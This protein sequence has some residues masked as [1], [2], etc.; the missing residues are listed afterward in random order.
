MIVT[1][2]AGFIGSHLVDFLLK[3]DYEV[4]GVDNLSTGKIENLRFALR[5]RNFR[6]FKDES[7]NQM[8]LQ[9]F[10]P[11]C[12]GLFHLAGSVGVI[13]V[14]KNPL[15]TF[16][17]NTESTTRILEAAARC[18]IRTVF[19]S[20]SEVY[21]KNLKNE[22]SETDDCIIG[23]LSELRWHYML[24][25]L[26]GEAMALS[27]F[28]EAGL[29]V[30]ICRLFNT[31]GPR[32][33]SEFGMV[34]PSFIKA[35][36]SGQTLKVY[37]DGGQSRVFCHVN[38]VVSAL[39]RVWAEKKCAGEIINVGGNTE[40]TILALAN[41]ILEHTNSNS[42]IEF[43]DERRINEVHYTDVQRRVPDIRKILR[44][45]GWKPELTLKSIIVES[46]LHHLK[47]SHV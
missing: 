8:L 28:Q 24:S 16:T 32:Q 6:L 19:T 26:A 1:G 23:E 27:Y 4:L 36:T 17:N 47:A 2:A 38:D 34:I 31:S 10:M 44:L 33:R 20:S 13:N 35:A 43:I 12:S 9:D 46:T 3:L 25:K 30:S 42:G 5:H 21:G 22:L 29:P 41:M 15:Q 18:G 14:S 40:T 39:F 37:G 7:D 11:D 45:T